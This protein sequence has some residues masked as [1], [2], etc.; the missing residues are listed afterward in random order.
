MKTPLAATAA[1]L[2]SFLLAVGVGEAVLRGA[3]YTPWRNHTIDLDEPTMH[4]PDPVLGWRAKPGRHVLRPYDGAGRPIEVTF[5]ENSSRRT[6]DGDVAASDKL[7]LIGGS[8]VQGWAISDDETLAWKLQ[9][10]LPKL[11]V[12]NLGTA[13]YGTYQSLLVLE[14]E[15]ERLDDVRFV[16]YGFIDGHEIRNAA[17]ADWLGILSGFSRRSHVDVPYATLDGEHR[18]VRHAPERYLSLPLHEHSVLVERIERTYM[19]LGAYRRTAERAEITEQIL[20]EMAAVVRAHGATFVTVFLDQAGTP[21][22]RYL[23]LVR[24]DDI[25]YVDCRFAHPDEMKVPIDGHPNGAMNTIWTRCVLDGLAA[26]LAGYAAS[27]P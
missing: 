2:A 25:R 27:S 20:R 23:D 8:F 3:G 5:L 9:N 1:L 18:L 14:R 10:A 19:K 7:V 6:R 21:V 26:E 12:I 4:E 13:G 17:T 22:D 24:N 16:L 15:L 11:D